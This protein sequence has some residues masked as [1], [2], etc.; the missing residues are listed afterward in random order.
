MRRDEVRMPLQD[1]IFR[2]FTQNAVFS[3]RPGLA[4]VFGIYR[5]AECI[6]VGMAHDVRATMLEH[7]S[8]RS[9]ESRWIFDHHPTQWAYEAMPP[10]TMRSREAQVIAELNP[11]CNRALVGAH[12]SI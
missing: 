12:S 1:R 8:H 6:Y 10:E 9:R 3:M 7:V 2:Q 11:V 4:G 5:G